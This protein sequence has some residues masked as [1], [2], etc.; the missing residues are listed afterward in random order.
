MEKAIIIYGSSTGNTEKLAQFLAKELEQRFSVTIK[1]VI[2]TQPQDMLDK[3]IVILGSSTW[4]DGELQEDFQEFY[5]VMDTVDLNGKK[6]AVF[7][8][9]DSSWEQ[10]CRAVDILEEKVAEINGRLVV[11]GFKWDGDIYEQ[12]ATEI[13]EWGKQLH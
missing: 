10:F 12:A 11:P 13:K 3:D 6:A 2:D 5:E 8:A 1:D 4:Y 9:G 7:G